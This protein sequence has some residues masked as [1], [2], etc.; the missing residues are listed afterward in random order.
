MSVR[1]F[2][3]HP[4]LS[5]QKITERKS[6][7]TNGGIRNLNSLCFRVKDPK[8]QVRFSPL[9]NIDISFYEW[10]YPRENLLT[11]PELAGW[12]WKVRVCLE[13]NVP[14]T[15]NVIG[16]HVKI[17]GLGYLGSREA[18]HLQETVTLTLFLPSTNSLELSFNSY[19]FSNSLSTGAMLISWK[20]V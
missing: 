1:D 15:L 5:S 7:P 20:H 3:Y 17:C 4:S 10:I 19:L 18:S 13:T 2:S 8:H 6:A 14:E 11:Q 12:R 9:N 16:G